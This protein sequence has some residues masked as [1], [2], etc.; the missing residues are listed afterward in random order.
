MWYL[1]G[2]HFHVHIFF[3]S[4]QDFNDVKGLYIKPKDE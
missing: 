4:V 1:D 2:S 3:K